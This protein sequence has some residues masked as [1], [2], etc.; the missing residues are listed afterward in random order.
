V[1]REDQVLEQTHRVRARGAHAGS[2]R[3]VRDRRDLERAAAPMAQQALA[4]DRMPDFA[5]LVDLL[6]L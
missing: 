5:D 4:Q 3:H 2:R 1:T 6:Q